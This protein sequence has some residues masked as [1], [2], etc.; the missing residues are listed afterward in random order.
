V[1]GGGKEERGRHAKSI[2]SLLEYMRMHFSTLPAAPEAPG[3]PHHAQLA[4]LGPQ[5][6][7]VDGRGAAEVPDLDRPVQASTRQLVR[8]LLAPRDGGDPV[9]VG[10]ELEA[11][12][13]AP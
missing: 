10:G 4:I 11:H 6:E 1:G 7:G 3:L 5:V 2:G 8:V 12:G 13:D 9:A